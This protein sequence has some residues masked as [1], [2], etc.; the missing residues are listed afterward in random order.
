MTLTLGLWA[1][2]LA[3]T[4]ALIAWAV[5]LPMPRP[6]N[7]FD[8]GGLLSAAFRTFAVIVGTLLAWLVWALLR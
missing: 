6:A 2:P 8:I 7:S 3:T 4:L 5:L 1:L